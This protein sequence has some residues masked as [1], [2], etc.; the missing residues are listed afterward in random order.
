MILRNG[1]I[2][3]NTIKN[4]G[5]QLLKK[6]VLLHTFGVIHNDIK[7]SNIL[8]GSQHKRNEVFIVDFGLASIEKPAKA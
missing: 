1:K 6:I 3:V 4:I 2:G 5:S 7:P 8:F